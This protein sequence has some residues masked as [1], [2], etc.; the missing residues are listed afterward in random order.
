MHPLLQNINFL[1]LLSSI[2]GIAFYASTVNYAG[3]LGLVPALLAS[4][5]LHLNLPPLPPGVLPVP[6]VPPAPG[7]LPAPAIPP[8]PGLT[9]GH[10]QI[11]Q[12]LEKGLLDALMS[13]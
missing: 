3:A 1:A 8:G 7:T 5:H 4:L 10:G 9:I 12:M 11:L 13:G 6:G 2:G